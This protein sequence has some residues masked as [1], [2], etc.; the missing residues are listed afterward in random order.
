LAQAQT[1]NLS[2]NAIIN[3]PV[4]IGPTTVSVPV[5]V[6]GNVVNLN[7]NVTGTPG[8]V[9]LLPSSVTLPVTISGSTV[10]LSLNVTPGSIPIVGGQTTISLPIAIT[11]P[12][13]VLPAVLGSTGSIISNR[14]N[15]TLLGLDLGLDRQVDLLTGSG[16]DATSV[17]S[18]PMALGGCPSATC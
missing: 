12:T 15:D 6:L 14:R 8:G 16:T 11:L 17:W 18:D 10:S 2:T 4:I 5:N 13:A 1:I 3:V 7:V 9:N